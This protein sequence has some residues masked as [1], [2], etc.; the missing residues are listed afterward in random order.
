MISV[1]NILYEEEG[2]N[3]SS[4]LVCFFFIGGEVR[5][6][7][8]FISLFG[9]FDVWFFWVGFLFFCC[10]VVVRFCR[11]YGFRSAF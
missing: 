4:F 8:I 3:K 6:C 5:V 2:K 10:W 9:R 7:G 11:F 1:R